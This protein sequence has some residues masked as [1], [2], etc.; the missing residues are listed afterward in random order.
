MITCISSNTEWVV[1]GR[2]EHI[3]GGFGGEGAQIGIDDLSELLSKLVGK[4]I[5]VR[6]IVK[7][8][9]LTMTARL[10]EVLDVVPP[11]QIKDL[12]QIKLMEAAKALDAFIASIPPGG[13]YRKS[14][15]DV[16]RKTIKVLTTIIEIREDEM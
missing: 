3:P 9:P 15:F 2:V 6:V 7:A 1:E 16:L 13:V 5:D 8:P 12:S 11:L 10:L 14:A 4:W